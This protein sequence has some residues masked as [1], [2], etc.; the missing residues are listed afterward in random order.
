MQEECLNVNQLY[1]MNQALEYIEE[2]L[3]QKIDF[4]EVAKISLTSETYFKRLFSFLSGVSL[5]EYIRNRR[6]TQ[7]AFELK[8]TDVKVIDVALKYGYTSPDAFT[9]AFQQLHGVTPTEA[10]NLQSKLKSYP[11]L[12]FRL[13][14]KGGEPLNYRLVE[15]EAF[16]IAGYRT[17]AV[18]DL[19]GESEEIHT[20]L[21]SMTEEQYR[22]LYEISNHAFEM[23]PLFLA[24]DYVEVDN[25]NM[26]DFYASVPV[27]HAPDNFESL[28]IPQHI[29]A[30]F[31]ISGDWTNINDTWTRIYTEWFPSS[32][33]EPAYSPEFMISNDETTEIWVA[34]K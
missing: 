2:H 11:R 7:A 5:A 10:R 8:G 29:W 4:K 12:S 17:K 19:D 30:V 21:E 6:L 33:Y 34:I 31:S 28:N 24:S 16:M 20:F 25:T 1:H 14:I 23:E 9:R 13:D 22:Q 3:D 15:K 32:Q 26:Q 27:D 18:V